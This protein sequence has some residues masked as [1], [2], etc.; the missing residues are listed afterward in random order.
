M[1]RL[2]GLIIA[3]ALALAAAA[4]WASDHAGRSGEG[5][6]L[7]LVAYCFVLAVPTHL[8]ML[9]AGPAI[10]WLAWSRPGGRVQWGDGVILA[11]VWLGAMG[12]GKMSLLPVAFA[13]AIVA[14]GVALRALVDRRGWRASLAL[15]AG[16]VVVG[17]V[18]ASALGAMWARALHDPGVNQ[19][20]AMTFGELAAAVAR[21]QYAVAPLWPRQAPL[22]I[23]L[24]NVFEY[25]DWQAALSLGPT[26]YPTV[27]RVAATVLWAM[28]GVVGCLAHRRLDRRS[29]RA[30]LILLAAGSVGVALYLNMRASPSFGHGVLPANA[31]REARERDYFFVFAFWIWGAWAGLGAVTMARRRRLH[32]WFGV[33]VAALPLAL[34]WRAVDRSRGLE[35]E[36]PR[37]WAEELLASAPRGA[38]VFLG[39]DNDSY[40]AWYAQEVLRLRRDLTLVTVPLLPAEWYRDEMQRR[41]RLYP[42]S[43]ARPW[44]GTLEAVEMMGARTRALGRPVVAPVT[45]ARRERRALGEGWVLHGLTY[46]QRGAGDSAAIAVDTATTRAAAERVRRWRRGRGA[47]PAIDGIARFSLEQLECPG[48]ALR[49]EASRAVRDSLDSLCNFR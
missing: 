40:P 23:Q 34:N 20:G 33:A 13:V 3:A 2:A 38:V 29:W 16:V 35:S 43:S 37:V 47:A 30:L 7:L 28:L 10:G 8:S 44:R 24:G 32:A 15:G 45:L 26:V 27:G 9:V 41:H 17:C 11:G 46:V 14:G 22:W 39:G 49:A 25:A 6:W 48:R 4:L 36:L 19:G 12:I 42:D 21:R 1:A 5:R 18:A 31:I